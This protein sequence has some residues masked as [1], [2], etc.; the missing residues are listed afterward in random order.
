MVEI[1]RRDPSAAIIK[2]IAE[3]H[4]AKRLAPSRQLDEE[5]PGEVED[6]P[7]KTQVNGKSV[8]VVH[9]VP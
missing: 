9:E 3:Q 8:E 1:L 5:A 7:A 6:Q 2:T 4:L